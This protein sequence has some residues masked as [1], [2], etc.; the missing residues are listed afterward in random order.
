MERKSFFKVLFG[1]IA[2]LFAAPELN[3]AAEDQMWADAIAYKRAR[4]V[5]EAEYPS[6]PKL[7]AEFFMIPLPSHKPG[8]IECFDKAISDLKQALAV[9]LSALTQEEFMAAWKRPCKTSLLD[10][11]LLDEFNRRYSPKDLPLARPSG[12]EEAMEWMNSQLAGR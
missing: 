3:A 5:L 9:S 7:L 4:E 11:A 6:A 2:G 10:C 1:G 12:I 8:S